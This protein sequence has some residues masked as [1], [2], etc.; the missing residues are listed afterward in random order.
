MVSKRTSW[1][2]RD[3]RAPFTLL[4]TCVC[5]CTLLAVLSLSLTAFQSVQQPRNQQ[6]CRAKN[7]CVSPSPARSRSLRRASNPRGKRRDYHIGY[8]AHGCLP[9]RGAYHRQMWSAQFCSTCSFFFHLLMFGGIQQL[10]TPPPRERALFL[11]Q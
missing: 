1:T 3:Y 6:A 7:G 2:H 10:E 11:E 4:H 9:E 8:K 5:A